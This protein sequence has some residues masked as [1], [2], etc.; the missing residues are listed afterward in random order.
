MD[1]VNRK[2]FHEKVDMIISELGQSNNFNEIFYEN[3][4]KIQEIFFIDKYARKYT[5]CKTLSDKIEWF[6]S[7]DYSVDIDGQESFMNSL[8]RIIKSKNKDPNEE[9]Y[10]V[11]MPNWGG[12]NQLPFYDDSKNSY[13]VEY[14][15]NCI[16]GDEKHDPFSIII[17]YRADPSKFVKIGVPEK[18]YYDNNKKY[19]PAEFFFYIGKGMLLNFLFF[20]KNQKY[21]DFNE[22]YDGFLKDLDNLNKYIEDLPYL[23]NLFLYSENKNYYYFKFVLEEE[24]RAIRFTNDFIEF[25]NYI[26]NKKN[27]LEKILYPNIPENKINN[28]F[29]SL[30]NKIN[31]FE[32]NGEIIIF[33]D[34]NKSIRNYEH[35]KKEDFYFYEGNTLDF[36]FCFPLNKEDLSLFYTYRY[37]GN[38]FIKKNKNDV[39]D[40]RFQSLRFK[41]PGVEKDGVFLYILLDIH[42]LKNFDV[43]NKKE[44]IFDFILMKK[45]FFE[46]NV[47]VSVNKEMSPSFDQIS[48]IIEKIYDIKENIKKFLFIDIEKKNNNTLF[49]LKLSK[50]SKNQNQL[51]KV[52]FFNQIK[53]T[54]SS[55]SLRFNN[56]KFNI[57]SYDDDDSETI[58]IYTNEFNVETNNPSDK[59]KDIY[60]FLNLIF[61]AFETLNVFIEGGDNNNNK[62]SDCKICKKA[63]FDKNIY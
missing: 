41:T 42:N 7:G 2:E 17:I 23:N 44:T 20:L 21:D 39:V 61:K 53:N 59:F 57:S 1:D 16:I 10:Y 46:L 48:D 50:N 29:F 9:E 26:I 13:Y 19:I 56:I 58:N 6:S 3:I 62:K 34:D 43:D 22:E 5:Y 55:S 32:K 27:E 54:L 45:L 37:N 18:I 15:L 38:F 12:G 30:Q 24:E 47:G 25:R 31:Y 8:V 40:Y 11:L 4:R 36:V 33:H 52:L 14:S 51:A 60:K 28:F 49:S 63:I 35:I